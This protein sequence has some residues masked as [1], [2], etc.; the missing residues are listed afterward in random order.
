MA[1]NAKSILKNHSKN[2]P[3]LSLVIAICLFASMNA[4]NSSGVR[5]SSVLLRFGLSAFKS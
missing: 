5:V 2:M 3:V 4:N 1:E